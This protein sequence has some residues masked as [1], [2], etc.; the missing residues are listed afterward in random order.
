MACSRCG[1]RRAAIVHAA[2]SLVRGSTKDVAESA[3]FVSRT[4]AEDAAKLAR[5]SA[6]KLA[7]LS[8][9]RTRS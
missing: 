7:R 6:Q 2:H 8:L 9:M 4:M 3:A 1:Q 5:S